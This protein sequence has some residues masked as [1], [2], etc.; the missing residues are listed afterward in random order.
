MCLLTCNSAV[1]YMGTPHQH[2]DVFLLYLQEQQCV[3]AV[4]KSYLA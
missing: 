4:M 2:N 3:Y 1:Y